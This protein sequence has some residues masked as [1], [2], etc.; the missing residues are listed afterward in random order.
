MDREV[1]VLTIPDV[2]KILQVSEKTI[3]RML[4]EGSIPGFKV[5]NQWRFHPDDFDT[6]AQG[7]TSR[8]GRKGTLP[9]L[10]RCSARNWT[11]FH[12]P[13]SLKST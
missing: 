7:E 5:A 3:N 1:P 2:A 9:A 12:F 8:K 13:G 11:R 4:Q 6:L 10:P